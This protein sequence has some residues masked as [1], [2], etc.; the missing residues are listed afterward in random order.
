[1]KDAAGAAGGGAETAI[2]PAAAARAALRAREGGPPV[3]VVA[4]AD[5]VAAGRR[6]LVYEAGDVRGTL[7]EP[8]LD[9]AA[10]ALAGEVLTTGRPSSR[11]AAAEAGEVTLYAEAHRRAAR[12]FVVGAGHIAV[13]LAELGVLLGLDVQVLDDREEF[14]TTDRFP[15]AA[16]VRRVDFTDPFREVTPGPDDVV[17]LVTRAHRYDFDCLSRIVRD[18]P[19][20]RYIGMVGSRRRVRAAYTALLEAGVPRE[21]LATVHAPIGVAIGAE[22]PAE[23]AVSIA[24][25]IT[26]VLR[27]VQP[28]GS[29]RDAED[30]LG[31]LEKQKSRTA[32]PQRKR[33]LNADA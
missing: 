32:E 26:A 28:G 33:G 15:S 21:R 11:T 9:E 13:P 10:R 6:L 3:A 29:L 20:P 8:G 5:G 22:T 27:G 1:M 19:L 16:T 25:E 17:V 12:L 14:A 30:V 31:R 7:G 18:D 23:I 2:S 4:A 24:A